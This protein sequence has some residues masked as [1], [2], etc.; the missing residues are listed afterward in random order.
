MVILLQVFNVPWPGES[1]SVYG[2]QVVAP[3][4]RVVDDLVGSF[5]CGAKLSLGWISGRS[6]NL[7]QDQIP[8]IKSSKLYPLIVVFRHLQLILRHSDGSLFSYFVQTVQALPQMIVITLFVEC[9]SLDAGH[10]YF[11]QDHDFSAMGESER[12]FSCRGSYHGSVGPQDV[13]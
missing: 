5:P 13:R 12:G 7:A 3:L 4:S 9:L 1:L 11:D 10:S 8:Y 2:F 6:G